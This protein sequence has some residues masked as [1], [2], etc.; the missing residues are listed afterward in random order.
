MF[1]VDTWTTTEE[2]ACPG[3][4]EHEMRATDTA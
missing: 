2:V 4:Y 1:A 3:Q